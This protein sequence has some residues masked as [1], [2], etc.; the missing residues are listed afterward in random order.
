MNHLNITEDK[1]SAEYVTDLVSS[2]SCGAI[3]LF[4]GT[5]R[6]NFEGKTVVTLEYEAYKSMALKELGNICKEIRE[7]WKNVQDIAIFHR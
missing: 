6:D 4:I 3:S 5:T 2:P 1:L 7:K